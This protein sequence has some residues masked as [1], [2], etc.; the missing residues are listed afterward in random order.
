MLPRF[1]SKQ[2]KSDKDFGVKL[3]SIERFVDYLLCEPLII[4][5]V[6]GSYELDEAC[7]QIGRSNLERCGIAEPPDS[8]S[9]ITIYIAS[10]L[11]SSGGHTAAILDVI[12]L[13][14]KRRSIIL[15][16][17]VCGNT[18]YSSLCQK[19]S[20]A[21]DIEIVNVPS[22][23]H[24]QKLTWIQ[25]FLQKTQ[26]SKVWLFNHHQ[27]SV[28]V[29]A[30]QPNRGYQLYYYHH[31]DDRLSLG[32]CLGFATHYDISP[33]N[34]HRCRNEVGLEN[35]KYLPQ[36]AS[37]L[38]AS[39]RESRLKSNELVTC[40]AAG[41]NK[42]EVDYFAQYVDVIPQV[43]SITGGRHIHIGRLTL[44]ARWRLSRL[45]QR[46]RV[47]SESFVYIP[48]V[49]SVWRAL[50]DHKVDL[51]IASF[52]YGG[53]KTMVEVMGSAI[54][55]IIH[56]NIADRLI[57]GLDMVYDGAPSWRAPEELY[58]LLTQFNDCFLGQ[59]SVLARAWYEKYHS[60]NV[61]KHILENSEASIDIPSLK[62]GYESD[63]LMHAWQVAREV[64]MMG[65]VKR[66]LW[67]LYRRFKSV[68]GRQ[69]IW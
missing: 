54:P 36:T 57:G 4:G 45:M 21:K 64:T 10:K 68:I 22:G 8:I 44:F 29:A 31:G 6:F 63:S 43:L 61:I 12:R 25:N 39:S 67:R 66:Q 11:Q 33:I 51:Y 28:A 34:Y 52:P 5:V 40:T 46:L 7:Q 58:N 41:F 3:A 26:P 13:S 2:L 60:T 65:L 16:T 50:Q 38:L 17:G 15:V 32:V 18:N 53:G 19:L 23:G 59:Q 47:P 69:A 37:D 27:D 24:L 48:Y 49:H 14:P 55:I 20:E 56:K 42:V 30:V 1:I 62:L 35:N 9:E